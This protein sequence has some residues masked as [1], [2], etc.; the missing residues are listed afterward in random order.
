MLPIKVRDLSFSYPNIEREIIKDVSFNIDKGE[1]VGVIGPS[2]CGKSTLCYTLNGI[3]PHTIKGKVSGS[4]E[5]FGKEAL[6]SEP[7]QL[8]EHIGIVLQNPETQLFAMTVEEEL[9]FG[10]ENLGLDVKEI[11]ERIDWALSVVSMEKYRYRFPFNLSGGQKQRV[12]IAASLTMLPKVLVLD[13]PTSQLDPKGKKDVFR[14]IKD[15]H[16]DMDMTILLV[17][18]E[19][20]ILAE[21]VD[22]LMVMQEGRMTMD[23]DPSDILSRV[24]SLQKIGIRPP[25]VAEI[26]YRLHNAGRVPKVCTTLKEAM[27]MVI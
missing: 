2:G 14:V 1:F 23:G 11:R 15:L 25:E 12:A 21:N 4:V 24:E 16:N 3:I 26:T 6:K 19:T 20:D 17:E 7:H 18:H 22:R 10:P 27:E 8:A 9:A 13:E 5:I